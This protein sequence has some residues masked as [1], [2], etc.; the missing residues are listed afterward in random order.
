MQTLIFS[1]LAVL[2]GQPVRC[3]AQT[4]YDKALDYATFLN[5]TSKE[6]GPNQRLDYRQEMIVEGKEQTNIVYI[7]TKNKKYNIKIF[8]IK[9]NGTDSLFA[10]PEHVITNRKAHK[11]CRQYF[12]QVFKYEAYP[13][14]E[15]RGSVAEH[16]PAATPEEPGKG[17]DWVMAAIQVETGKR[18]LTSIFHHMNPRDYAPQEASIIRKMNRDFDLLHRAVNDHAKSHNVPIIPD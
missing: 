15:F 10:Y 1:F 18:G 7:Y 14:Y 3:D 8:I 12:A 9:H 2:L 16:Q 6:E 11:V 5:K 17:P 4:A 13:R